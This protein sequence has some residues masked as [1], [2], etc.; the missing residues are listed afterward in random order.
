MP[1]RAQ[2]LNALVLETDPLNDIA[3]LGIP[4]LRSHTPLPVSLTLAAV[5][6]VGDCAIARVVCSLNA[7]VQGYQLSLLGVSGMLAYDHLA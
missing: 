4:V 3:L 2:E 6:N 1:A 7:L 5:G